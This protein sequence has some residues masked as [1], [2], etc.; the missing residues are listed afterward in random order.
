M[1][2][3]LSA[4]AR[5]AWRVGVTF[6]AAWGGMATATNYQFARQDGVGTTV[7]ANVAFNT[8]T[9][10]VDLALSEGLN[11]GV[12]YFVSAAGVSGSAAVAYLVAPPQ[13]AGALPEDDP[14]AEAFG[15]DIDWLAPSLDQSGDAPEIRGRA[16]LKN[17]LPAIAKTMPGELYHRPHDGG[18]LPSEVNGPDSVDD[19]GARVRGQWLKDSRVRD[20]Q[21]R[22]T[23]DTA[24][25]VQI[26]AQVTP[27]A[28]DQPLPVQV[29]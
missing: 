1:T 24:G 26:A 9:L 5:S 17:D 25:G 22:V 16:C 23:V 28:L 18:G 2:K 15:V 20:A 10:G 4:A 21:L 13:P 8:D 14:E 12:V 11:V 7:V 6:D 29:T 19:I 27:A 3:L